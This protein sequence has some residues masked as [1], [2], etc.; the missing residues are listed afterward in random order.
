MWIEGI[1]GYEVE[2]IGSTGRVVSSQL[3]AL[4]EKIDVLAYRNE[5]RP[6]LCLASDS[7]AAG[8]ESLR[9]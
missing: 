5:D 2:G 6:W 4:R 3:H 7:W 1:E 9:S 8:D